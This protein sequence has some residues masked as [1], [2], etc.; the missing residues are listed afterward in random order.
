MSQNGRALI[1]ALNQGD[2]D[3]VHR[4]Q[5]SQMDLKVFN[6]HASEL[7]DRALSQENKSL[8]KAL[9]DVPG[10]RVSS[11]EYCA[12]RHAT[13]L[14]RTDYVALL[15][16]QA[17]VE[18]SLRDNAGNTAL[19]YA[20]RGKTGEQTALDMI[21]VIADLPGFRPNRRDIDKKTGLHYAIEREWWEVAEYLIGKGASPQAEDGNDVTPMS[22][23]MMA[24]VPDSLFTAMLTF[25]G[26]DEDAEDEEASGP[27]PYDAADE[28]EM[29]RLRDQQMNAHKSWDIQTPVTQNPPPQQ[30]PPVQP[31]TP[32]TQHQ[33]FPEDPSIHRRSTSRAVDPLANHQPSINHF[34]ISVSE[35]KREPKKDT[36]PTP[37]PVQAAPKKEI[38]Q[39]P[40]TPPVKIEEDEE[41]WLSVLGVEEVDQ[42]PEILS[43][44]YLF[45]P[46][47]GHSLWR[48]H[49][50][51]VLEKLR[52]VNAILARKGQALQPG[53][54]RRKN[55]VTG[56]TLWHVAAAIGQF[57]EAF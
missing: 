3:A 46:G 34:D 37:E 33:P 5:L 22:M 27:D 17:K 40:H 41:D 2:L 13:K 9:L 7:F 44:E 23:A 21:K 47:E 28:D 10:I 38:Q 39:K 15:E 54:F 14:G 49:R 4:I 53:D 52:D 8:F 11:N 18:P 31:S 56:L 29:A 32:T 6:H 36:P 24:T 55:P 12:L 1:S 19:H 43:R 16:G 50:R 35:P 48:I 42:L 25:S 51:P 26:S 30:A 20:V 57:E 45:T